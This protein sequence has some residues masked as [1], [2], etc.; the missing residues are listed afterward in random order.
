M[1]DFIVAK[2]YQTVDLKMANSPLSKSYLNKPDYKNEIKEIQNDKLMN[3]A[4][5]FATLKTHKNR[6][7]L[8]NT[9]FKIELSP[10][11]S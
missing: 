4:Y 7:Y 5:K 10:I 2:I 8:H 9:Y 1:H 3:T 6:F 11:V